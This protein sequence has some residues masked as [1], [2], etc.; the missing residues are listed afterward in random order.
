MKRYWLIPGI[1]LPVVALILAMILTVPGKIMPEPIEDKISEDP[2]KKHLREEWIEQMHL[3]APGVDWREMDK[4]TRLELYQ[5]RLPALQQ[6]RAAGLKSGALESIADGVLTGRWLEKGSK[7]LAGRTHCSDIDF[8]NERLYVA[9]DGGQI[10]TA[11]PDGRDWVSLSDPYRIDNIQFLRVFPND[12]GGTRILVAN[13]RMQMHYTD[14]MGTTWKTAIGLEGYAQYDQLRAVSQADGT[15]YILGYRNSALYLFRST[16]LGSSFTRIVRLM[17]KSN[18]SDLWTDRFGKDTVFMISQNQVYYLED[19]TQFVKMGDVPTS[20]GSG[21]V[22]QIQLAGTTAE[23]KNRL[24][25]MY[26]IEGSSR[27]Y[28]MKDDGINWEARGSSNEGPFMDNSFTVSTTNHRLLGFGGV[29]A[30]YSELG[31]ISWTS[32]NG[33]GEYY[34][35]MVG[36]LHA[37]IP[38]IEF[39]KTPDGRE[40]TYISTDGGTYL[41][42][43][44]MKTVT[45]VSLK[46]LNISQYYSTYTHRTRNEI[47]YAGAQ[48]QGFQRSLSAL[49]GIAEFEQIISGD[50]GHIVSGDGGVSLWTVYPGFAMYLPDA[51][52]DGGLTMWDFAGDNHFWMPPLMADPYNPKRVWLAG[53][54]TN[55]GNHLWMLEWNNGSI[56]PTEH[57]YDFSGNTGAW[58]S[59]M[60]YSPINRDYRYVLN[61]HGVFYVS[62]DRGTTWTASTNRGPGSH[63]FYGN[64]IVPSPKDINT[65]YLAGSGYS[66]SSV[67]VSR[68]G[69]VT[70]EPMSNGLPN[71]LI[72][73]MTCNEDG[74]LLFAASEVAPWVYVKSEDQWYDLSGIG[75]PQ[76]TWWSVDYVPSLKTARFGTYGRGI[77]DFKIETF[78]G[79]EDIPAQEQIFTLSAWPNPFTERLTLGTSVYLHDPSI[80]ELISLD[81]RVVKSIRIEEPL[82]PGSPKEIDVSDLRPGLYLLSVQNGK[83]RQVLRVG[84]TQ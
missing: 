6:A 84:K 22:Q 51:A 14:D 12:Q 23:G 70:F 57:Q 50:Y 1:A 58:I 33:W 64:A 40:I 47:V 36:K 18:K 65:I 49:N 69:G 43:D 75:A 45:N 37:D 52:G 20:F 24:Y 54:T 5:K 59:S 13:R 42:S 81:G 34:G 82:D 66:G 16:D 9:S 60:A 35:D 83:D 38:E 53:G 71:T 77:W 79:I 62:S 44:Q 28:G 31:G 27:F 68:D 55:T 8:E 17:S 29:E 26:R 19:S 48:D 30:Y 7:N 78:T 80:V 63:Y 41:S 61:S 2:E 39:F 3:T 46:D 10:W 25:A 72:Y 11:T 67:W 21:E 32:V 74:S 73:E 15:I 76:Q 4:Q 56:R